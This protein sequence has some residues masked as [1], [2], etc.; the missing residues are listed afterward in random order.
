MRDH[1]QGHDPKHDQDYDQDS[2]RTFA[3]PPAT[4]A[5]TADRTVDIMMSPIRGGFSCSEPI[6]QDCN[7]LRQEIAAGLPEVTRF[8]AEVAPEKREDGSTF[9]DYIQYYRDRMK[10]IKFPR[11]LV[12]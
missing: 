12:G 7:R 3:Y 4:P 8:R 2:T 9:A 11:T 5:C 1:D 6:L 10:G